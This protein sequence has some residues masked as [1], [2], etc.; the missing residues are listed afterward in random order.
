MSG[1]SP[2]RT[3]RTNASRWGCFHWPHT[4]RR[5]RTHRRR[6]FCRSWEIQTSPLTSC[7]LGVSGACEAM[8]GA[9]LYRAAGKRARTQGRRLASGW[10][11]QSGIVSVDPVPPL[12][13]AW[14]P[15]WWNA[16]EADFCFA[17]R[18]AAFT[19]PDFEPAA[20]NFFDAENFLGVAMIGPLGFRTTYR[21]AGGWGISNEQSRRFA[22]FVELFRHGRVLAEIAFW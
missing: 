6:G 17:L 8:P 9:S 12:W 19:L 1:K 11:Y 2:L 15:L 13:L 10:C 14:P 22:S 16:W 18:A 5:N 21:I 4:D 3:L 7:Q 20:V